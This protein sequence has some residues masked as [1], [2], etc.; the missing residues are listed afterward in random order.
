[1]VS[2]LVNLVS[3]AEL[4]TNALLDTSGMA[5][6][7]AQHVTVIQP[8]RQVNFVMT[9]L[10]NV[11]VF[12]RSKDVNVIHVH[13]S[14]MASPI[15][16]SVNVTNILKLVTPRLDGAQIADITLMD[17]TVTSVL[18]GTMVTPQKEQIQIVNDA[19]VQV[20]VVVINSVRAVFWT[21]EEEVFAITALSDT[22]ETNVRNVR[23]GIL[24]IH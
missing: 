9:R 21:L 16:K 3:L 4:A 12:L 19:N 23:T 22:L 13:H 8:V 5:E 17:Q 14:I 18:K 11:R 6:T 2:V 10:A 7:D 15:V 1:M 24:A 20:V